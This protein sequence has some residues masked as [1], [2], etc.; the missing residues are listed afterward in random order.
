VCTVKAGFAVV[1]HSVVEVRVDRAAVAVDDGHGFGPGVSKAELQTLAEAFVDLRLQRV[2]VGGAGEFDV[3]NI[4]IAG[5]GT[6]EVIGQGVAGCRVDTGGP[7]AGAVG[8]GIQAAALHEEA[9][10]V[11]DVGDIKDGTIADVLLD[12]EAPVID[13][14]RAEVTLDSGN[15]GRADAEGAAEE[16]ADGGVDGSARDRIGRKL[17]MDQDLVVIEAIIEYAYAAADGS[18]RV[19]EDIPGEADT[20]G[21]LNGRTVLNLLVINF[22]ALKGC[23]TVGELTDRGWGDF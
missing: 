3:L 8:Q 4:G 17:A 22:H 13:R 23:N 7:E 19:T 21:D 12:A 5:E 1:T 2:I 14:W 6:E 20:R 16:V 18:P 9:T 11:A 15:S 10:D